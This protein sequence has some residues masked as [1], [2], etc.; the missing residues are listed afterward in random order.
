MSDSILRIAC[1]GDVMCGDQFNM[2]GWGAA[3]CIDKQG[4]AFVPQDIRTVFAGHD[5]VLGNVECVLSDVDRRERSLRSMSMRGRAKTAQCLRRWGLTGA[6]VANN[7]I[8][9]HGVEAARDTVANLR[10]AGLVVAGAGPDDSFQPGVTASRVSVKG[11]AVSIIGACLHKGRYAFRPGPVEE[12]LKVVRSEAQQGLLVIVSIH[13]GDE[14]IDR[15]S[16]W[17]RDLAHQL[18]ASGARLVIGH[19][20]HVMQGIHVCD[21]SLVAYSLGNF[22]FDSRSDLTRWAAI[23]SISV[24]GT[25][26]TGYEAI[27]IVRGDEFRPLLAKDAEMGLLQ[28]EIDRR[29]RLVTEPAADRAEYER[30]YQAEV[31]ELDLAHRRELWR[32]V[33]RSLP[34][35]GPV[36]SGQIL[37]RPVRRRLGWW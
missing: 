3:S 27:P 22:I 6:H 9:E 11:T 1:V 2:L 31:R 37:I 18:R 28:R 20:A 7:H 17:Q 30:L 26:V 21:G 25:V 16:L 15:P 13:W 29:S 19:H 35:Y 5:L 24:S 36:L 8:L 23:L 32:Y 14:L 12:I 33:M 4:D 34:R 10:R